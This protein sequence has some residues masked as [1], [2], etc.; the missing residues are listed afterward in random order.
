MAWL[1]KIMVS[2]AF[3]FLAAVAVGTFARVAW[4]VFCWWGP[5]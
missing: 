1:L 3:W 5:L 2:C 4:A